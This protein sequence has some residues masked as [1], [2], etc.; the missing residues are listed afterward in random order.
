[1][2]ERNIKLWAIETQISKVK[3]KFL[4]NLEE[5]LMKIKMRQ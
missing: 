5:K 2:E 4:K 3:L 1:M